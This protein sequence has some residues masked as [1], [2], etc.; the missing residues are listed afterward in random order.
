MCTIIVAD[1]RDTQLFESGMYLCIDV[2]GGS[3]DSDYFKKNYEIG[4][5]YPGSP[6]CKFQGKQV[7]CLCR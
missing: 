7:P 4:K 6:T 2:E 3:S 5:Q 1:K